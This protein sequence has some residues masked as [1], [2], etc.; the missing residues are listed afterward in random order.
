MIEMALNGTPNIIFNIVAQK[1]DVHKKFN[2]TPP[3]NI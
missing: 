1:K 3:L 2:M